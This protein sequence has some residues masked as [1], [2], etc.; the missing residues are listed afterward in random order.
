M[1]NQNFDPAHLRG[2]NIAS[3]LFKFR[4][5][6][7]LCMLE[8]V[9]FI[10]NRRGRL[11]FDRVSPNSYSPPSFQIKIFQWNVIYQKLVSIYITF[12][13][14]ILRKR[15]AQGRYRFGGP[16]RPPTQRQL[17]TWKLAPKLRL[18]HNRLSSDFNS[19][20]CSQANRK[21]SMHFEM[22]VLEWIWGDCHVQASWGQH[23][24]RPG[25]LRRGR[26]SS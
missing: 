15:C 4:L 2:E 9:Y 14:L 10:Q 24:N 20:I 1:L 23:Q 6:M 19:M 11:D 26:A 5:I 16:A 17:R 7:Y 25:L 13:V 8:H 3:K 12:N 21:Q 22:N 18:A